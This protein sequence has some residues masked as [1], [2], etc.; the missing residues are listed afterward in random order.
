SRFKAKPLANYGLTAV[1]FDLEEGG[2]SGSQ[3]YFAPG[4]DRQLPAYAIHLDIFGYGN[5][6]FATPSHSWRSLVIALQ[7]SAT[8]LKLPVRLSTPAEYPASDHRTMIAAGIETLGIALIDGSEIDGVLNLL[9]RRSTEVPPILRMI[10]TP[11]DTLEA[12]R[13]EDV[14]TAIPFV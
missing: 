6:V 14:E 4:P 10:H 5:S 1:F 8:G 13:P 2:L 12:T 3:A 11:K 9:A 7:P